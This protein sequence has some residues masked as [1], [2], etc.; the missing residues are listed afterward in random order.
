MREKAVLLLSSGIDSAVNLARGRDKIILALTFAY[1]QKAADRELFY[2]RRLAAFYKIAHQI[3]EL[4]FYYGDK[5]SALTGEEKSVPE[6]AGL[7]EAGEKTADQV[8][9]PNRNGVFINIAAARAESLGAGWVI[10]GANA[11]EA[12]TFPDNSKAFIRAANR[13]LYFSTRGKVK[14]KSYTVDFNKPEILRSALLL[15]LP[16]DLIWSCYHGAEQMCGKCESCLRL[17]KG[18]EQA[19]FSR[20]DLAAFNFLKGENHENR[21][22]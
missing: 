1:G 16:L 22:S 11:E 21:L 19:G 6:L 8:W 5:S 13:A 18:A 9:L 7:E 17:T 20:K 3:I 14:L 12:K 2:A 4:P 10:F 15:N